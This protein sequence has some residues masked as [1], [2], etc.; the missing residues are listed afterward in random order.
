MEAAFTNMSNIIKH[1]DK[2]YLITHAN[3]VAENGIL[4]DAAI[5]VRDGVIEKVFGKEQ[6]S[7][8]ANSFSTQTKDLQVFDA[9]KKF[10]GPALF[11][12]HIHGAGGFDTA[13][14]DRKKNLEGM[15]NFLAT[16]G[17]TTFQPT[18]VADLQTLREI[19]DALEQSEI[20]QNHVSG[21]YM[22]GPFIAP[23]KKGGLPA[24]CIHDCGDIDFL[25]QILSIEYNSKPIIQ[26]MT[27]APELHGAEKIAAMLDEAGVKIAWGHSAAFLENLPKPE[28]K[29][30]HLT[31]LFNAMNGLDHRHP[32]LATVPFLSEYSDATFELISDTVHVKSAMLS[33]VVNSLGTNRMCVISDAMS[34]AGL[35]AGETLYLGKEVVC[36]GK[37]SY[38]KESGT[39]IGSASLISDTGRDLCVS[40]SLGAIDFFRVA[41]TN[42]CRVV[43][44]SDRGTISEGKRAH[45]ILADEA[46]N[47]TDV[48]C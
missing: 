30:A 6:I 32:G 19:H 24:D 35:G 20:L 48:F 47:I 25:Q 13:S 17:I 21:V 16:R 4:E 42:P 23:E 5:V 40:N 11:D 31:H 46:L 33:L 43:G 9:G 26:T 29:K 27:L 2:N 45:I 39:L 37:A 3:V 1:D 10:A 36:D 44:L 41:S 15:A 12:M 22:E 14:F 7:N 18:I 8:N 38:Y 28:R 34:G